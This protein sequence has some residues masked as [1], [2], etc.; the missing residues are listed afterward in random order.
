VAAGTYDEDLTLRSGVCL[1]GA[2]IGQTIISKAGAPGIAGDSVSYVIVKDLTVQNSGGNQVDGG[3][4]MLF[5]LSNVTVQACR[6]TGNVATDGG[7]MLVSGSGVT[8]D[9]CLI[10]GNTATN[11]GAGIV[12]ESNSTVTL[13]NVTMANNAWSNALG[14]G[15]V[16]GIG[17]YGSSVHIANSILWGNNSQ[18]LSGAG[19]SV[20]SSDVSG[21]TGGTSNISSNPN[22]ASATDYHLQVGSPSAGMGLY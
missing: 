6:L 12:A 17:S 16:G 15:G 2:G 7:G 4:I 10:D 13:T 18:N 9:H 14:N 8:V 22:F 19:L 11:M 1:E 5:G 20:N 21:W 3:G